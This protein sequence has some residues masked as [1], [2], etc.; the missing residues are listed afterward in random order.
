MWKHEP[1]L[2]FKLGVGDGFK[3]SN[4][5]IKEKEMKA[6]HVDELT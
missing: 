5:N 4:P 3:V 1:D 6:N 2:A